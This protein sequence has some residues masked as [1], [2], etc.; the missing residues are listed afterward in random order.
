[1]SNLRNCKPVGRSNPSTHPNNSPYFTI[2]YKLNTARTRATYIP[3]VRL[4]PVPEN[5]LRPYRRHLEACPHRGKGQNFTLCDCPIWAYGEINGRPFRRSLQTNE[6][7]RGLKRIQILLTADGSDQVVLPAP[8]ARSV[9]R[10][11]ASFLEDASHRHLKP[12]STASYRRTLERLATFCGKTP[13]SGLTLEVLS[14]FRAS[15]KVAPRTQRKEIEY[16]RA[17]CGFC[18]LQGWIESNPAKQLRPPKITDVA[19]MPFTREEVTRLIEACDQMRGMWEDDTPDVRRRAKALVLTLLYSGLRVG[20]VAQ[21]RRS[22][23]E[24]DGHLV[25]RTM[26]TG[27]PLKVLLNEDAVKALRSLPAPGGNPTYFFWSGN[28]DLDHCSKSLWRTI[29]RVGKV[30]DVHAHPHRFRDTFSVELLTKGNDIRAVQLLLGHSSIRTTEKHYAHFVP[31][32][33]DLLDRASSTLDFSAKGATPL[34]V[35]PLERRRRNS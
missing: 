9:E 26:K 1:M 31:A 34:L 12:S 32:H 7:N 4:A 11:I 10:A 16:L 15:R 20:D 18:E 2:T 6:W 8:P 25:L 28:G 22:A 21:L 35:K 5:E 17:F 3:H 24:E 33:Q 30:A 27:V 29:A 23:L 19:T 14:R 13:I